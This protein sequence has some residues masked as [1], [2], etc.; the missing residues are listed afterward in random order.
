MTQLGNGLQDAQRYQ[1]ALSV[2][3]ADLATERRIGTPEEDLLITRTNL[4]LCLSQLGRNVESLRMRREVFADSLRLNAPDDDDTI[5]S[6]HHLSESLIHAKLFKEARTLLRKNIRVARRT[7]ENGNELI[8]DL[9]TTYVRAIYRDTDSSRS[10]VHEA[11]AISEDTVRT[12][13][14]VFGTEHPYFAGYQQ[15]LE[16]AHM[17][18]ADDESRAADA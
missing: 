2:L 9:R 11:V 3:E 16:G 5:I 18:L 15:D 7:R 6:A 17:R 13:R 8:L 14:R 1:D 12:G 10:D 4:A